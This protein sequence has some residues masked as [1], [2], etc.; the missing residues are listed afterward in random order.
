MLSYFV[1]KFSETSASSACGRETLGKLWRVFHQKFMLSYF[2]VKVHMGEFPQ[3]ENVDMGVN[4][5][6]ESHPVGHRTLW[7]TGLFRYCCLHVSCS[8]ENFV[9]ICTFQRKMLR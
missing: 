4:V 3:I 7:D 8:K 1:I 5:D 9:P 2:N 6:T